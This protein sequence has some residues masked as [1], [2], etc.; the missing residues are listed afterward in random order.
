MIS[1]GDVDVVSKSF[2]VSGYH[3]ITKEYHTIPKW[4]LELNHIP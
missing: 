1:E 3:M 2:E 4:V